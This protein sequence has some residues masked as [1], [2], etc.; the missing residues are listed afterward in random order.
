[1]KKKTT[2]INDLEERTEIK[3]NTIR[4]KKTERKKDKTQLTINKG[5]IGESLEIMMERLMEGEGEGAIEDRDLVYNDSESD[6]VNPITNIRS[7]KFELM[8]EEKIGHQ[9]HEKKKITDKEEAEKQRKEREEIL[10]KEKE[11]QPKTEGENK[12]E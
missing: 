2:I 8:L 4:V 9:T 5:I 7:D 6:T 1:M 11:T 12:I 10:K 3:S